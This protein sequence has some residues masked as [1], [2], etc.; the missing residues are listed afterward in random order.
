LKTDPAEPEFLLFNGSHQQEK[1]FLDPFS[2]TGPMP[3]PESHATFNLI[4]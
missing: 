2:R 4:L 1:P 3:H